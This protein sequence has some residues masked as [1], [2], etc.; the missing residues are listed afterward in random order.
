MQRHTQNQEVVVVAIDANRRDTRIENFSS[1]SSDEQLKILTEKIQFICEEL[2]KSHLESQW[3]I[4]W[5]EYQISG[6]S[7]EKRAVSGEFK[8]RYKEAM[9]EFVKKYPNLTIVAGTVATEKK[10]SKDKLDRVTKSY[11]A[12]S[13]YHEEEMKTVGSRIESHEFARHIQELETAKKVSQED[14]QEFKIIRNTCYVFTAGRDANDDHVP[15]IRKHSKTTPQGDSRV[16]LYSGLRVFHPGDENSK[17]PIIDIN[18]GFKIAAEVCREHDFNVAGREASKQ[19]VSQS[20]V[21]IHF[22]ISDTIKLNPKNFHGVYVLQLDSI[23]KPRLIIADPSKKP[24]VAV[25]MYQVNLL[26]DKNILMGPLAP[27]REL[28]ADKIIREFEH[29][30]AV[31]ADKNKQ[32]LLQHILH[33]FKLSASTFASAPMYDVLDKYLQNEKVRATLCHDDKRGAIQS[34]IDLFSAKSNPS[35]KSEM[36]QWMTK[37]LKMTADE[38]NEHPEYQ[39]YVSQKDSPKL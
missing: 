16:T 25:T 15:A 34:F 2:K 8:N 24:S 37:L 39:A 7:L 38:R 23:N 28:F 29:M 10:G 12:L 33:E 3:I 5:R 1:L 30:I 21:L 18:G 13:D 36:L 32:A 4:A 9:A 27:L 6:G 20:D 17:S 19:N 35:S 26:E 31:T 14:N 22:V 11:Q